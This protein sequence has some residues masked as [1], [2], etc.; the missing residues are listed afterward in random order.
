MRGHQKR[1]VGVVV[2]DRMNKTRRVD[3]ERLVKHP[4]YGKYIRRRTKCYAH[5]ENNES[6]QGDLV[7]IVETRPLSKLKRWRIVRIV[8]RA[9]GAAMEVLEGSTAP[10]TGDEPVQE[11]QPEAQGVHEGGASNGQGDEP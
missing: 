2:S 9:P 1:L 6:R 3:V 11:R 7:E 10:G 5:D 4:R 8:R